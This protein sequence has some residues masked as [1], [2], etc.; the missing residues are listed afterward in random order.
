MNTHRGRHSLKVAGAVALALAAATAGAQTAD[1][2]DL[3]EVIVTAQKRAERIQDV[4]VAVSVVAGSQL[5][6]SGSVQLTDY[7]AYVPGMYVDSGGSP[8]LST[9]SLRGIG[10]MGSSSTVGMY[11]D[12]APIGSSGIYNS[13]SILTFDLLP[14]DVERIEVLRG[15]QGTLYGA[16]SIGG[17]LKYVTIA[18]ALDEFEGKIGV[19]ALDVTDGSDANFNYGAR[20]SIPIV[21]DSL[22]LSLSYASR[23]LPA[24]IDNVQTGE[25]DVNEG[26]QEGARV[27]LLWQPS[28]G[29]SVTLSALRQEV[30]SDSPAQFMEDETGTPL[31]NGL[32]TNLILGEPFESQYDQFSATLSFELGSTTLTSVTSYSDV[33]FAYTADASRSFGA[34]LGGILVDILY[35]FDQKK[36]T[37]EVRLASAADA[38]L[39]WLVGGFY[40]DE[41]NEVGQLVSAYDPATGDPIP[42]FNPLAVVELPNEYQEYAA[43]VNGT[44]KF[45]DA[46]HLSAGV[47]YARNDQ[48]FR[49]ISSGLIVPPANNPG[50]SDEDVVTYSLSPEWHVGDDTMV[51][52]R[53]ATGYRPGGPNVFIPGVP[54][55]VASDEMTSYEVG[56]KS[57]VAGGAVRLEAAAFYMDWDDIQLSVVFPNGLGGLANSGAAES[58]GIEGSLNWLVGE[59]F[60]VGLNGAYTDA[61]LTEDNAQ[62]GAQAGDRLPR[63]PEW[64]GA[65]FADYG[66]EAGSNLAWQFGGLLRYVGD[67]VSDPSSEPG[68]VTAGSYAT[69]DLNA[70]L[71]INE[72]WTIRAY[73]RN[74]AD[75]DGAISRDIDIENSALGPATPDFIG[76]V[77]LQPRT[78]GIGVELDF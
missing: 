23:D 76:V 46:F 35:S 51:Y 70:A 49:Q 10:P 48:E 37:Q 31:G 25:T 22:G 73:A 44:Y 61:Q 42:G 39:E 8:G 24:Y 2:T 52:A 64:S 11:I 29:T 65:L 75:E 55:T 12:E 30:D 16:S 50:T 43:F 62:T 38:R 15:P 66:F 57:S 36:L 7:A 59:N 1:T 56:I 41:D 34:A 67:R 4:P 28:D 3:G 68:T 20:V 53:A 40:T 63:T 27:A 58:Q 17:Q 33:E 18:P 72:R 19:E 32:S 45:T 71:T 5:V 13:T 26:T 77:P 74:V 14:Y 47:R 6:D 78:F 60:T 21:K 69:I 54:P 9:I